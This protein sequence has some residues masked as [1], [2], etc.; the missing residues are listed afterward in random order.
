L[1]EVIDVEADVSFALDVFA[2]DAA[3]RRSEEALAASHAQIAAQLDELRRWNDAT[4][5]R[6]ERVLEIKREMNDLLAKQG[7]P[8]RY[9]SAT[10]DREGM[11]PDG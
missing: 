10:D 8:P 2:S 5:G 6:E 11:A 7:Q 4:L 1:R 3:R 9:P